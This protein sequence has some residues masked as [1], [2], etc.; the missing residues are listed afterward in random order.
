MA[1]TGTV[2]DDVVDFARWSA[3]SLSAASR[4]E[5]VEGVSC[6]GFGPDIVEEEIGRDNDHSLVFASNDEI[7]LEP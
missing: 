3:K 1:S 2:F 6:F 5:T 7:E 4:A